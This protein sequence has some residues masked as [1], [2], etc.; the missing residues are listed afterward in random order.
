MFLE[1]EPCV[2]GKAEKKR[3]NILA[4]VE[5]NTRRK[6]LISDR[7]MIKVKNSENGGKG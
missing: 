3:L 1:E 5:I 6:S 2:H 7:R 4:K